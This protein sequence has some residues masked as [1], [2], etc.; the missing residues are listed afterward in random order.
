MGYANFQG[1]I[2]ESEVGIKQNTAVNDTYILI[3]EVKE[4]GMDVSIFYFDK[5]TRY[6]LKRKETVIHRQEGNAFGFEIE[7]SLD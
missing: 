4:D 2:P 3:N 1:V 6:F 7:F 5:E